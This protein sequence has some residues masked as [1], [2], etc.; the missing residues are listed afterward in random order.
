MGRK[1]GNLYYLLSRLTDS[2]LILNSS[3]KAKLNGVYYIGG[4]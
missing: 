4:F 3:T 2:L 1:I